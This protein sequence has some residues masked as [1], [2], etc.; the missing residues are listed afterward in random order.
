MFVA[1]IDKNTSQNNKLNEFLTNNRNLKE[2]LRR[3]KI[4]SFDNILTEIVKYCSC[5][6]NVTVSNFEEYLKE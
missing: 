1:D 5:H 3:K 4:V 6:E 2:T